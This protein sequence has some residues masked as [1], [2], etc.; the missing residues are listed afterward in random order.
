MGAEGLRTRARARVRVV[1]GSALAG[2][3][4]AQPHPGRGVLRTG[5]KAVHIQLGEQGGAQHQRSLE[6]DQTLRGFAGQAK[7]FCLYLK[8][9]LMPRR[10]CK[11]E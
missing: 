2:L 6:R 10:S 7:E 5:E 4:G 1:G 8:C 11:R 9:K 3:A